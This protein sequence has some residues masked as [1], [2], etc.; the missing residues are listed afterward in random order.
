MTHTPL[1]SAASELHDALHTL[2]NPH[3]EYRDNTELHA[4]STYATLRTAVHGDQANTGNGGG[5]KSRPP[6]WTDAHDLLN[7]IDTEVATWHRDHSS[8]V[9]QVNICAQRQQLNWAAKDWPQPTR[10]AHVQPWNWTALIAYDQL[11][12]EPPTSTERRLRLI[13]ARNFRPDDIAAIVKITNTLTTWTARINALLEPE[14][15]KHVSAPC[16]ACGATTIHRKDSA[17]EI[18]RQPALQIITDQGCTC[19]R[20]RAHWAP[21]YYLHLSRVLG[22]D[23]PAGILE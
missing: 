18:V 4:S 19:L 9:Y 1:V 21:E 13:A 8:I 22:F 14:H 6:F 7:E 15:I 17:G 2:I 5:T 23:L 11:N 20:C 10:T 3:I 12:P 16:P